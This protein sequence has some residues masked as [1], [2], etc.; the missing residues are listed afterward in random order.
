MSIQ[1]PG[2]RAAGARPVWVVLADHARA[3]LIHA[4]LTPQGR[5]HLEQ[6]DELLEAWDERQGHREGPPHTVASHPTGGGG[7]PQTSVRGGGAD[8]SGLEAERRRRFALQVWR[9]LQEHLSV[10]GAIGPG[11]ADRPLLFAPPA[12]LGELRKHAHGPALDAVELHQADI[13]RL[14]TAKLLKERSLTTAL[15][16]RWT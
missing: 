15:R 9:W 10:A 13:A 5:T 4:S 16:D 6:R 1:D 2:T 11:S 12:L 3:R 8:W 7:G 14:P